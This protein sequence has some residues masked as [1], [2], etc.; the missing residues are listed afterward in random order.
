M[1]EITTTSAARTRPR[2][3]LRAIFLAVLLGLMAGFV[4]GWNLSLIGLFLL[5]ILFNVR[6]RLF[7]A[8]WLFGVALSWMLAP[9][10]YAVGRF[11]LD[12][13]PVGATLELLGDTPMPALFGWDRYTVIGGAFVAAV[14]SLPAFVAV[15]GWL[16]NLNQPQVA[17]DASSPQA[18]AAAPPEGDGQ[19]GAHWLLGAPKQSAGVNEPVLRPLG[20]WAFLIALGIVSLG[21]WWIAP[22][23][24][25]KQI[26]QRLAV[27]NGA[28]VDAGHIELD[29]WGG[30]LEIQDLA[31]ANPAEPS[32]D[33]LRLRHVSADLHPAALFSGRLEIE[34]LRADGVEMEA[35][36]ERLAKVY[37][38]PAAEPLSEPPPILPPHDVAADDTLPLA[39]FVQDWANIH[40]R[41]AALVRLIHAVEGFEQLDAPTGD[42]PAGGGFSGLVRMA[43]ARRLLG[44]PQPTAVIHK[45]EI[46]GLPA[47]F[48]LG[49]KGVVKLVDLSSDAKVCPKPARIVVEAP[50][51]GLKIELTCAKPEAPA[52]HSFEL[53][54]EQVD[55]AS[56]LASASSQQR[57]QCDQGNATILAKGWIEGDQLEMNLIANVD[58]LEARVAGHDPLHDLPAETWNEALV[59]VSSTPIVAKLSGDWSAPRFA[60]DVAALKQQFEQRLRQSGQEQ[61][62]L[63]FQSPAATATEVQT[64]AV[65]PAAPTGAPAV[66]ATDFAE[67]ATTERLPPIVAAATLGT[68]DLTAP[69]TAPVAITFN[70]PAPQPDEVCHPGEEEIAEAEPVSTWTPP[71]QAVMPE[72]YTHRG[73]YGVPEMVPA[74]VYEIPTGRVESDL[75]RWT[76]ELFARASASWPFRKRTSEI[77][78]PFRTTPPAEPAAEPESRIARQRTWDRGYT[79]RT[80]YR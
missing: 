72:Q 43:R 38:Q 41:A 1:R 42:R 35:V 64:V 45:L 28:Q 16:Q 60:L 10:S 14:L 57:L 58:Q 80:T 39:D 67:A 5:V 26:L 36:R 21:F 27:V 30:R 78:D 31:L 18:M 9:L 54:A 49:D 6:A 70:P 48:Q 19:R 66:P 20:V 11:A 65:A 15:R 17:R 73:E 3:P 76:R 47:S 24:I 7:F 56:V 46:R 44:A 2:E 53:R 34:C 59:A 22:Q 4:H 13:T 23:H 74:D 71:R 68:P 75:T 37:A 29:L 12:A 79:P 25:A 32:E 61:L 8:I 52:R 69:N 50:A 55:L 40:D 77:E 62:A 63:A 33:R 51:S